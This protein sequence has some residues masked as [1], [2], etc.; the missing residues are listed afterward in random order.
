MKIY[1]YF[2][3]INM[4]VINMVSV[5]LNYKKLPIWLH[6]FIFPL[7]VYEFHLFS[8]T[9]D[10]ISL[11]NLSYSGKCVVILWWCLFLVGD[12]YTICLFMCL[13][14]FFIF[15]YKVSFQ[16]F[17]PFVSSWEYSLKVFFK[18]YVANIFSQSVT[19]LQSF[20]K[21]SLLSRNFWFR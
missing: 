14:I 7:A 2:I 15:F 6:D 18:F 5:C 10:I 16:I 1:F 3:F 17:C 4:G 13:Y 12:N 11:F 20:I 9:C 8:P 21:C 19:C